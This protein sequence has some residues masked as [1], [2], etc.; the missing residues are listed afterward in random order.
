MIGYSLNNYL[1]FNLN[2]KLTLDHILVGYNDKQINKTN[3]H[4]L[5]KDLIIKEW[6]MV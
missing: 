5:N 3:Q 4:R 1:H 6:G 2:Y